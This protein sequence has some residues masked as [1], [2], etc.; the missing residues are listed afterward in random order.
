MDDLIKKMNGWNPVAL[1]GIPFLP[2]YALAGAHIQFCAIFPTDHDSKAALKT[3]SAI[4]DLSDQKSRAWVMHISLNMLRIIY[5]LNMQVKGPGHT[6]YKHLYCRDG[7]VMIMG[8]YVWKK[9]IPACLDIYQH[10]DG[11]YALPCAINAKIVNQL[12]SGFVDLE[13]RPVCLE[14]QPE[15]EV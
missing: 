2:C 11:S 4:Y 15:T 3:V 10:L 9:C 1:R 8:S 7:F 13:I 14:V 6:L 12:R 5:H